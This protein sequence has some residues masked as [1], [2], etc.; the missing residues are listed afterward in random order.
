MSTTAAPLL[1]S[2]KQVNELLTHSNGAVSILDSTWFMPNSPRKAKD[3]FLAR[4]IP[5]AQYLDLDE[6]ASPNELGLKH[7]MPTPQIFAHACESLGIST[8]SHVIIYDSHGIFSAPRALLM[9]RFF[10]HTNSSV[11]DGGLPRWIDENYTVE[12]S[13]PA[14]PK[15]GSYAP[16]QLNVEAIRSYEQMVSNAALDYQSSELVLDARPKGRFTGEQ[17]EPRPGLPS[18]HMPNSC[19][20]TFSE[21]LQKHQTK[22]GKEYTSFLPPSD[23]RVKLDNTIPEESDKIIRGQ[24]SVI[25]SCGSGMTASVLWLGLQLLGAPH[26][27]LYDESWTGY[28][29][30]PTSQIQKGA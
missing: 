2:P 22:D 29:Q 11:I 3:E 17:P 10:G 30:R 16:P 25:T 14:K 21:F 6:V 26:V 12:T 18:G 23:I 4:R 9:F 28:A 27:S 15:P 7:M 13:A 5:G 8:S 20:L 24:K 19:S 1:L